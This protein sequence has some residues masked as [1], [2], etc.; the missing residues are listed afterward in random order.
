MKGQGKDQELCGLGA[1]LERH[2]TQ[3]NKQTECGKHSAT[4]SSV[5]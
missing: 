5:T 2:E 4:E 1:V 3:T